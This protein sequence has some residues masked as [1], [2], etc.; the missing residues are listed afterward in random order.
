MEVKH[1][2]EIMDEQN[3]VAVN[4]GSLNFAGRMIAKALLRR[5]R[6][7]HLEQAKMVEAE[8]QAEYMRVH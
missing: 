3:P 6:G 2:G 7:K 1:Y 4:F 8:G 5:S